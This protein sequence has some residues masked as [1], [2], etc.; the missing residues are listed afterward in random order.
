MWFV[1]E[2]SFNRFLW[3][4]DNRI[5]GLIKKKHALC[6]GNQI[7]QRCGDFGMYANLSEKSVS[8]GGGGTDQIGARSL[9][10]LVRSGVYLSIISISVPCV[11]QNLGSGYPMLSG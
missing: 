7:F 1:M 10:H 9:H 5:I 11:P 8:T 2:A 6:K 3:I 4:S